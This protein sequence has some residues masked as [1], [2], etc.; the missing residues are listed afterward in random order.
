MILKHCCD[1]LKDKHEAE[2]VL[3]ETFYKFGEN[4]EKVP[5]EKTRTWLRKRYKEQYP[6]G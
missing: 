1:Y 2:D 5:E 4:Y 3:Q 6:N